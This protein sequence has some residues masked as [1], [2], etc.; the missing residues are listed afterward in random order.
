MTIKNQ[1]QGG[2]PYLLNQHIQ[3]IVKKAHE[4]NVSIEKNF[5]RLE[6]LIRKNPGYGS[7]IVSQMHILSENKQ[8]LLF[9]NNSYQLTRLK[10][11]IPNTAERIINIL[12][13]NNRIFSQFITNNED[14]YY[15]ETTFSR[16]R[17]SL[18]K[19]AFSTTQALER[20][21]TGAYFLRQA[22][23]MFPKYLN[24]IIQTMTFASLRKQPFYSHTEDFCMTI[25]SLPSYR[26]ESAN[27]VFN[28][29]EQFNL[30]FKT[31]ANLEHA[32]SVLRSTEFE[33]ILASVDIEEAQRSLLRRLR[34]NSKR[35]IHKNA[36]ILFILAKHNDKSIHGLQSADLICE[37]AAY[38]GD[39]QVHSF[40][41]AKKISH[42][43]ITRMFEPN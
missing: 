6:Q 4:P 24:L 32:R 30:L 3:S 14:L 19:M 42:E 29:I 36:S 12:I 22:A 41:E 16:F 23:R 8:F 40:D 28:N 26:A 43:H 25:S 11:L 38:T 18:I 20:H 15:T 27:L 35:E 31:K 5:Q 21:I 1:K 17:D 7:F 39:D 13:A 37:I 9:F 33:P 10:T 34:F 2:N